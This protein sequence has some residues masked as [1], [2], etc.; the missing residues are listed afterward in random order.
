MYPSFTTIVQ[1]RQM[2]AAACAAA[3]REGRWGWSAIAWCTSSSEAA[4]SFLASSPNASGRIAR[5]GPIPGPTEVGP[6]V[7]SHRRFAANIAGDIIFLE[8]GRA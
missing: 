3:C 2:A 6:A 4:S 7:L 5:H 1:Y 8:T